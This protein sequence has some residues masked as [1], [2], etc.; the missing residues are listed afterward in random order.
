MTTLTQQFSSDPSS[1]GTDHTKGTGH[2]ASVYKGALPNTVLREGSNLKDGWLI[3]AAYCMSR[4]TPAPYMP[5][6]IALHIDED[7]GRFWALIEELTDQ[8]HGQYAFRWTGGT[9][10]Y[11][12]LNIT[13]NRPECLPSPSIR[14]SFSAFWYKIATFYGQGRHFA[15]V[16]AH[17]FNWMKRGDQIV[18][19][20][21]LSNCEVDPLEYVRSVAGRNNVH[22]TFAPKA[23]ATVVR[24]A[25]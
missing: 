2:Y 6:V 18:L 12:T 9:P 15:Y 25:A 3:W 22:I 8:E 11:A 19:T 13:K 23:E 4:R 24:L 17:M 16:D 21:P 14:R 7:A 10:Y 1:F 20:D 5:K